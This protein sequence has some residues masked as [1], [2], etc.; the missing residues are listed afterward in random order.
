MTDLAEIDSMAKMKNVIQETKDYDIFKRLPGNRPVSKDLVRDLI[1]SFTDKPQLIVARPILVNEYFQ[2]VDGQHRKEALMIMKRP[3]PYM[4]VPKLTISDARLL[5]ALQR[6]WGL[7]DFARSYAET[8]GGD[9]QRFIDLMGEYHLPP[10]TL[11]MYCVGAD[12]GGGKYSTDFRLGKFKPLPWGHTQGWLDS[13]SQFGPYL[14]QWNE[15][16]FALAIVRLL[17][18]EDYD[19]SRMLRKLELW[20]GRLTHRS[21]A[22]DY[23]RDL[24][25]IYNSN[26][27][28]GKYTR[29]V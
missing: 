26:N 8:N 20:G 11:L 19:H 2:V 16:S 22:I 27:P 25:T 21:G 28:G 12:T 4:V 7:I 3:I 24:E 13:L 17:R 1:R 9:Y 15:Q 14:K 6:S 29:F 23:M 18:R 5:N 10:R